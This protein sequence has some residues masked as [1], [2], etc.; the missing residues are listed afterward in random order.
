MINGCIKCFLFLSI[1]SI[2]ALPARDTE[3]S[4]NSGRTDDYKLYDRN[5]AGLDW[6]PYSYPTSSQPLYQDAHNR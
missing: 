3:R 5:A 2:A 4:E 6:N 1:I